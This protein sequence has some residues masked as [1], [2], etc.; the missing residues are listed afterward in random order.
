MEHLRAAGFQLEA[1]NVSDEK[2]YAL[3]KEGGVPDNAGSCHTAKVGGYTIEGHVPA[4]DIRRLL[5][6]KPAGVIGLTVPGMPLGSPGM[7]Q[8]GQKMPYDT[9]AILKDG[10]TRVF[11][12]HR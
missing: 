9:L 1:Q 6:E 11:A 7:E 10:R 12:P 2:L 3:S 8:G 4:A 5:A